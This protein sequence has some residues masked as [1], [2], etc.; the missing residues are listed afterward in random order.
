[1][2]KIRT[3]FISNS[4]SSSSSFVVVFPHKPK[5]VEDLKQMMFGKQEWHYTGIHNEN[6]N[7][8]P[9]QRI[10]E[11]VFSQ[12]KNKK[13]TKEEITES[14]EGGWFDAYCILPG[15]YDDWD[16]WQNIKQ[17]DPDCNNKLDEIFKKSSEINS[18]R[19]KDI[20]EAFVGGN[21]GKYFSIFSFSD[22]EGEGVY[23]HMDIFQRL[24][25]IKTSYH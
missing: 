1:M 11:Y 13:A 2:M 25:H 7:D 24:E 21:E 18:K 8:Y 22:N 20:V 17:D 6:G 23:D 5:S 4:S 14:I 3:G 19:V 10:A 16:E 15:H 9:T 12:M